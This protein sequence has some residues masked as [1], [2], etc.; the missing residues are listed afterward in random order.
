MFVGNGRETKIENRAYTYARVLTVA[1]EEGISA[2]ELPKF[3]IDNNGIDE[4]RRKSKDGMTDAQKAKQDRDYAHTVL[5]TNSA[6]KTVEMSTALQPK[7]GELYSLALVRK[8]ADGSGDIVFGTNNV[9]AVNTVLTIAG[10]ALSAEAL[11]AV[12]ERVA[13]HDAEYRA[14]NAAQVAK[15]L[16]AIQGQFQPQAQLPEGVT[17]P[18]PETM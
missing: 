12:Q 8:N 14:E 6:I 18:Q 1:A 17:I 4:I 7:D 11:N 16:E 2:A 10:K 5:A 3:I 13:K 15:E 9:S